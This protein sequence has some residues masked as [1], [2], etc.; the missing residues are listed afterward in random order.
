M[1]VYINFDVSYPIYLILCTLSDQNIN[2]IIA[3]QI[4]TLNADKM[5][6]VRFQTNQNKYMLEFCTQR[7]NLYVFIYFICEIHNFIVHIVKLIGILYYF[8]DNLISCRLQN[9]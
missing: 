1:V 5:Y 2:N 4:P 3:N 9:C 8:F 6:Y 7:V